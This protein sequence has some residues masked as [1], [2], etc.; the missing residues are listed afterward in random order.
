MSC[1]GTT[2]SNPP[3]ISRKRKGNFEV[4]SLEEADFMG[5]GCGGVEGEEAGEGASL[6]WVE[7]A[8][9]PCEKGEARSGDPFHNFGKGF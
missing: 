2:L 8:A 6:M 4:Q 3:L 5:K 9:G 7:K 1:D